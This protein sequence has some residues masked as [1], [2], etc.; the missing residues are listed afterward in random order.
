MRSLI[1][2]FNPSSFMSARDGFID[3]DRATKQHNEP[4]NLCVSN[5]NYRSMF[6]RQRSVQWQVSSYIA[7]LD[8]LE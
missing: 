7:Y 2:G 8:N 1:M 3:D 5:E 4:P 6:Q